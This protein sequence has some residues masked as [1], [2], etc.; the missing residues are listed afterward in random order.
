MALN[1]DAKAPPRATMLSEWPRAALQLGLLPFAWRDLMNAPRGDGRPVL[2]LPGLVN[3]DN[4]NLV[5]RRYLNTL[6]YRAYPWAL[7]RN[8]GPRVIGAEGERLFERIAAIHRETG[9]KVTLVGVSL[10]GIMA[11]V[12]AHRAPDLVREV[13]TVCSPFAG[14][15]RATNVWRVFELASGQRADDPAVR[16]L[17]EEASEPL[18][19]PATAIWSRSDGLVNGECCREPDCATAR[20]VEVGNG[21]L[22]AQMSPEVLRAVAEALGDAQSS[23]SPAR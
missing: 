2:A 7:G 11:R 5:L 1:L 16:A 15:P 17:L 20:S 12:A 18:P 3:G 9:Q 6:G 23:R 8:F 13:V 14:L 21:H 19:V 4:S 10:G 22:L